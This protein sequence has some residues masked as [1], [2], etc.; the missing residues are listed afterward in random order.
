MTS[1]SDRCCGVCEALAWRP[2]LAGVVYYC[3]LNKET[4]VVEDGGDDEV[5]PSFARSAA[6]LTMGWKEREERDDD[7]AV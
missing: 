1:P 4:L 7:A 2:T 6:C 5:R 3:G